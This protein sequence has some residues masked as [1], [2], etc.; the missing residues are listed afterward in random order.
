MT[1]ERLSVPQ[2]SIKDAAHTFAKAGISAIPI[3][4]GSA[5]ELFQFIVQP[6]LDKRR[7]HWMTVVGEKLK[8]LETKGLKLETL[9]N[10]QQF[11]SAVMYASQVALRTHQEGKLKALQNAILNIAMNQGPDETTQHIFIQFVDDLT[12]L[13]L[14][15]LKLFQAPPS[16]SDVSMGG[17]D[18][19]LTQNIPELLGHQDLYLQLWKDLFSRGLVNTA[20]L[21]VLMMGEGFTAKRTTEMG[22]AFLKFITESP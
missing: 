8:E 3:V 15:I 16:I 6:P 4:G 1:N 20:G 14:R 17:L 10:H 5:A 9:Q 19:V 12:E 11:I 22:D 7:E 18:L 21:N 13:H 2:R